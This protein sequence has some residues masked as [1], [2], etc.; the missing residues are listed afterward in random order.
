MVP[1]RTGLLQYKPSDV[2]PSLGSFFLAP[3]NY[4]HYFTS[5]SILSIYVLIIMELKMPPGNRR[6]L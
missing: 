1:I 2:S 5:L 3:G 4:L 6:A